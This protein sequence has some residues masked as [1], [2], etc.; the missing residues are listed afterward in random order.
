[1][2]DSAGSGQDIDADGN[3]NISN[4]THSE[5][6][7]F[8]SKHTAE[9]K[10]P[11]AKK[12]KNKHPA[13][14]VGKNLQIDSDTEPEE[15]NR[16]SLAQAGKASENIISDESPRNRGKIFTLDSEKNEKS[17]NSVM[18][19]DDGPTAG[20]SGICGDLNRTTKK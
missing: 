11:N 17:N 5:Q 12:N 20:G 3:I 2:D 19:K 13:R 16:N 7:E 4:Y 18:W 6:T 9:T 1:M 15:I 8:S 10:I 14:K